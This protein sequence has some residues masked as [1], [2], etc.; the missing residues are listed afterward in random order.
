MAANLLRVLGVE[1]KE[2]VISNVLAYALQTSPCFRRGFLRSVCGIESRE[3]NNFRARPRVQIA[4]AGVPDFVLAWQGPTRAQLVVVENKL[5]AKEGGD[6]TRRYAERH[7]IDQLAGAMGISGPD[8]HLI[9]LTLFPDERLL[10]PH[11]RYTTHEKLL[12]LQLPTGEDPLADQLLEAW[13]ELVREFYAAAELNADERVASRLS[14]LSGLDAGF[15]AFRTLMA[16]VPLPQGVILDHTYRERQQ[17]REYYGALFTRP[18]WRSAPFDISGDTWTLPPE[19]RYIH[20]EPQ[21]HTIAKILTIYIHYE[22]YPY[23][24]EKML[25]GHVLDDDLHVYRM[26]RRRFFESLTASDLGPFR[27][28]FR[29]IQMASVRVPLGSLTV[30]QAEAQL[31]ELIEVATRAIDQTLV[32]EQQET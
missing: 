21:Y 16:R 17:G 13:F 32:L 25:A 31:G 4:G 2:D 29:V 26:R 12:S 9:Y 24:P 6:Q 19:N 1:S 30:G 7:V 5:K 14:A 11:F 23:K 18:E 15:L 10:S 22:T 27:P 20:I 28:S 8:V 3:E